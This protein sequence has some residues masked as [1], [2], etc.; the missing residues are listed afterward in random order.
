MESLAYWKFSVQSDVWSFGVTLYEMFSRGEEPNF[1]N[2]GDHMLLLSALQQGRRLPCPQRCP[3]VI[4][5]DLM[6]PCWD[7]EA[8]H[9]PSFKVLLDK[10]R[11]VANQLWY[12]TMNLRLA[13]KLRVARQYGAISIGVIRNTGKFQTSFVLLQVSI[14]E[15]LKLTLYPY[16]TK[17]SA[18]LKT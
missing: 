1:V 13:E 5:R 16:L 14:N 8:S 10:L 6:K 15:L 2:A 12:S 9:R 3:P 18:I 11:C 7:A 4:Y 17:H